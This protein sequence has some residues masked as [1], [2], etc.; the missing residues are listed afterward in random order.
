M[1][2][3]SLRHLVMAVSALVL[4]NCGVTPDESTT[5][6]DVSNPV[7][8]RDAAVAVVSAAGYSTAAPSINAFQDVPTN[9]SQFGSIEAMW[10]VGMTTGCSLSG[11][12]RN[13][14]PNDPVTR[15]QMAVFLE[16][17][18]VIISQPPPNAFSDV[19]SSRADYPFIEALFG[20]GLAEPCPGQPG[21]FCPDDP[22][23][24][25]D[26][27][28]MLARFMGLTPPTAQP[29]NVGFG[30]YGGNVG[31][32]TGN[33]TFPLSLAC[34]G[35]SSCNYTVSVASLGDP[36]PGFAKDYL[37]EWFCNAGGPLHHA[38]AP[39]E[40]G[41]GSVVHLTCP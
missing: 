21:K 23:T 39:A 3:H 37:A 5:T 22:V 14:C 18:F 32:Q 9:D 41:F 25:S 40:A 34:N 36:A 12:V 13:Y 8:R 26:L 38:W 24:P 20:A 2:Y 33:A 15:G 35:S 16:R 29:I 1:K 28:A 7:T 17:A 10:R 6:D 11:G 19:P 4:V 30:T 27:A 31:V